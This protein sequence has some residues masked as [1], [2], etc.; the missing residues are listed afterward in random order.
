MTACAVRPMNSLWFIGGRRVA[1]LP[2][3]RTC[4]GRDPWGKIEPMTWDAMSFS[5]ANRGFCRH[6]T[7]C[8]GRN[9]RSLDNFCK[10]VSKDFLWPFPSF[11]IF[12]LSAGCSEEISGNLLSSP[13]GECLSVFA[14]ASTPFCVG[15]ET[16][17]F[18]NPSHPQ[19]EVF[20]VTTTTSIR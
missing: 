8:L 3:N 10:L 4:L 13:V 12:F 17:T 2:T 6:L 14:G 16:Q 5:P 20:N 1:K 19:T 11:F 18:G 15:L 9:D 7:L